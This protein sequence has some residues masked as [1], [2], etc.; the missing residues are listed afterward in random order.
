MTSHDTSLVTLVAPPGFGKT[1]V[2]IDMGFVMLEKGKDVLYLSLRTVRSVTLAAKNL[3]EIIGIPVADDPVL[4][5]KRYLASLGK[6]TVLILD[7]AEDLQIVEESAFNQFLEEVGQSAKK[8]VIL[9]TSR[10]RLSKLDFPFLTDHI[11][12]KPLDEESSFLFLKHYAH[13]I[14]DQLAGQFAKPNVCGGIPLLLKLTASFLKTKTI[15]PMELHRKLQNCPHS[16]LKAKDPSIRGLY[17]L[18][19]VFYS[20][21]PSEVKKGLSSLAAFPTIFTKE[22]AKSV[23]FRDEDQLDFQLLLSNLVSHSLVQQDEVNNNLQYS[24]HPLVQAFCIASREDKCKGYN[25][26]I[27]QFSWHY[28]ALLRQLNDDFITTNCKLAIDGYQFNKANI[29]HALATSTEDDVLKCYGVNVS[30]ETVNF[31]AKVM[32]W[33]EFMSMYDKFLAVAKALSDQTLYSD[34]LVSIGFKQLSYYGQG[35]KDVAKV[36]N[37]AKS[38]LE[39]AHDLQN[40]LG[41]NGTECQ[42]HC[43]CKLGLCT[44]AAGDKEKGISLIRQGIGVRRTLARSDGSGKKERMH[45]AAGLRDQGSKCLIFNLSAIFS[46][47]FSIFPLLFFPIIA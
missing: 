14:S 29:V 42:G 40:H 35:Y 4:Q 16:F 36:K 19:E 47:L 44:F 41:I 26:A 46:F 20:H 15:E 24:L 17:F 37:E 5:V 13:G 38:N 32:T 33:D 8:L 43:K 6:E 3:L 34:C 27:R 9:I 7:N 10:N 39:K 2:A 22:E 1:A 18:F 21:L 11:P 30:T 31:L 25:M 23:L 28:L 45:L 12:L